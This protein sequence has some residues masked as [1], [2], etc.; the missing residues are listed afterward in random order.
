MSG[1]GDYLKGWAD[2]KRGAAHKSG[3]SKQYDKGYSERYTLEQRETNRTEDRK[4]GTG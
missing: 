4:N 1:A 2:C 3:A